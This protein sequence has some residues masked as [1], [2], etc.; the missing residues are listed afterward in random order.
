MPQPYQQLSVGMTPMISRFYADELGLNEPGS[1]FLT[2]PHDEAARALLAHRFPDREI[3]YRY[4]EGRDLQGIP[5][6]VFVRL[7]GI[8][9]LGSENVS[10]KGTI[11]DFRG[12]GHALERDLDRT[13]DFVNAGF[14]VFTPDRLGHG[15][16]S[17][18]DPRRTDLA[19]ARVYVEHAR[20]AALIVADQVNKNMSP[21]PLYCVAS[22]L[23]GAEIIGAMA[24]DRSNFGIQALV[25]DSPLLTFG[26]DHPWLKRK[27]IGALMGALRLFPGSCSEKKAFYPKKKAPPRLPV[28][29]EAS[30]RRVA[31]YYQAFGPHFFPSPMGDLEELLESNRRALPELARHLIL[32]KTLMMVAENDTQIDPAGNAQIFANLRRPGNRMRPAQNHNAFL[33]RSDTGLVGDI[34]EFFLH[35]RGNP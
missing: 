21:G 16:S 23:G 15:L 26:K 13:E 27:A 5:G 2:L 25:L 3:F 9:P 8:L 34:V 29:T 28:M 4:F 6:Q 35:D 7:T 22:S 11:L 19:S 24:V 12:F 18:I 32:P 1:S 30:Y 10:A 14:A 33:E 17:R 20:Q 31:Q